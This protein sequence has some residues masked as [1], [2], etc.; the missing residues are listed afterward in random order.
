MFSIADTVTDITNMTSSY[1][2]SATGTDTPILALILPITIPSM[3]FSPATDGASYSVP[4]C[5]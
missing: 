3:K 1:Q 4:N 5:I 2:P